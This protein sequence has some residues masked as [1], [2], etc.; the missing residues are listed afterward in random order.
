MPRVVELPETMKMDARILPGQN[1]GFLG[2]THD[3]F[4]MTVT[5]DSRVVPPE[6][7]PRDDTPPDRLA[8]R[9]ALL[10]RFDAGVA[11]WRRWAEADQFDRFREQALALLC[12]PQV[13]QAFDLQREPAFVR[14]NYGLHRHGQSVLLARRLV[15]AGARFVSV[16]WGRELQDWADGHGLRPANN[17][18]DTHRNHFP[19]LK[20]ELL[21][22][23]DRALAALVDDLACR[24]LLGETLVVWMGDFGRTSR[25]DRKYASRDHWPAAN[26][27]LFAGAGTPGGAV[28]GR[29]D[30][31]AAEVTDDPVS[32]ADR[33]ATIF[34]LLGVDAHAVIHD[35]Q[36]RA[37]PLSEG[38]P[39]RPLV[40]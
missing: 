3:P 6:F 35:P 34:H 20:N 25:I 37:Y 4:R 8:S 40:A 17:P 30:R 36:G 22:R 23:A 19:L 7:A 29:T 9:A 28:L 33:T 11:D 10:E 14:E 39:I 12:R 5:P 38:R 32:P 26:T 31:L 2:A 16:Y 18:W 27:V 1:A 21:P 13:R 15:E 24:G